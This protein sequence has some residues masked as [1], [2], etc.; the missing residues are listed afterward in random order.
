M[1][2]AVKL[3][4]IRVNTIELEI[5]G[6][7]PLIMHKWSEKALREMREKQSGR[8]TKT[9]EARDPIQEMEDAT[10]KTRNGEYAIP[11]EALKSAVVTAAHKD[12]GIEK[13]LVRKA[14]F[15][16]AGLERLLPLICDEPRL[17]EDTVRVGQGSADLRYRPQFDNWSVKFVVEFDADLLQP[18]DIV[19]LVNRAGFGVGLHEWRPE[20][21]GD[22]GRFEIVGGSENG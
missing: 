9:R 8:K 21:G 15:I 22:Y 7:T 2:A 10:Y 20:K 4:P 6:I 17:R 13:T 11:V 12:I 18:A 1:V 3:P 14:L 16:Q 19:N 5:R